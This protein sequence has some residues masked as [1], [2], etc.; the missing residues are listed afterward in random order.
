M[1]K[2]G[3]LS[4]SSSIVINIKTVFFIKFQPI[5]SL[6]LRLL[7]YLFNLNYG[8]KIEAVVLAFEKK[9]VFDTN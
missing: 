6:D 2:A 4:K 3:N 1:D 5:T 8:M 9:F 7:Y